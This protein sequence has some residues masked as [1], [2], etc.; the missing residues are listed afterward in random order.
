MQVNSQST[1]SFKEKLDNFWYYHKW[2]TVIALFVILAIVICSFQMCSKESYDIYIMYAG[3][4]EFKRSSANGDVSEYTKA[5]SS[6]KQVCSDFDGDGTV[7]VSFVNLYVPSNEEMAEAQKNPG[8]ELNY[9]LIAQDKEKL[10]SN[11]L[12]SDYYVCIITKDVYDKYK[13]VQELEMFT[14][15]AQYASEGSER[16]FYTDSAV[17]LSSTKLSSLPVFSNLPEDTLICLRTKSAIA[18]HFSKEQ[19]EEQYRRSVEVIKN[20]LSN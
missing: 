15:L 5:L 3:G 12:Y 16:V 11:I 14:P 6:L 17:Y 19:T 9:T 7:S 20:I 4:H 8:K 2:H 10:D 13:T 18:S 1:M